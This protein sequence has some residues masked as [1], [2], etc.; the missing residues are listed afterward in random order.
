MARLR[1]ADGPP[2]KFK[3][4]RPP[5]GRSAPEPRRH[6][7]VVPVL[8]SYGSPRMVSQKFR[9]L[10]LAGRLAL[11]PLL[12]APC[13][14]HAGATEDGAPDFANLRYSPLT[15]INAGN[16]QRLTPVWT[17]ST[18]VLRGHEGA[19]LVVGGVI[20]VHTPFPNAVYALDLDHEGKILW[21]YEPRQDAGVVALMCCDTVSRGLG[22]ADGRIFL[23][24]A[25]A[26]LVALDAA[27]GAPIWSASNADPKK[28]ATGTSA[29]FV[30]KDKVLVGVSGGEF[31]VRGYLTAYD[32]RTGARVWRAFSIGPDAET[33]ID[34]SKTTELGKPV[35]AE[36]EPC[37]LAGRS[38][39]DRRRRA[40]GPHLL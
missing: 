5:A 13:G 9:M 19:P 18:G 25:D 28:G 7:N 35:G 38:M 20:Y 1:L 6:K 33:L 39:E 22:Y 24:Q 3:P 30:V 21:K 36:F 31:G 11:A 17:F 8:R 15:E 40:L 12:T 14:A 4:S 2:V 32:A 16:V 10:V 34:P 37:E 23:Y 29:P 27:T 26:T